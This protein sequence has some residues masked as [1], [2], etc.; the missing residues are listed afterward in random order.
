MKLI[1][2]NNNITSMLMKKGAEL[3]INNG[4]ST[5]ATDSKTN[6]SIVGWIPIHIS[7]DIP[8]ATTPTAIDNTVNGITNIYAIV[9]SLTPSAEYILSVSKFFSFCMLK[10]F[11]ITPAA[12]ASNI[13]VTITMI[14]ASI[15]FAINYETVRFLQVNQKYD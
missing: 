4:K 13:A 8:K 6:F 10:Q 3:I 15:V 5:I 9:L 11:F 7:T 12:I 14:V 2:T 1:V